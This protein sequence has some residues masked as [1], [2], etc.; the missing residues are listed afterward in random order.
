MLAI[1]LV[2]ANRVVSLD[3]L[4]EELWGDEP[5]SRAI[6]SLQAYVSHLRRL[7][8]PGRS[9]RTP[10]G[11]LQTRPPGYR[12][13]VAPD[14]LDASRFEALVAQGRGLLEAGEHEAAAAVLADGLRLWRGTVLA[15]F[16]DETFPQAERARLEELRLVAQEDRATAE[17][18]LGR[19]ATVAAELERLVA[20]HR[21]REGLHG[22]RMLALY[23]SRPAGRGTAGL[24]RRPA[25]RCATSSASTPSP[26]LRQLQRQILQQSPELDWAPARAPVDA[27]G[28]RAAVTPPA[29]R[30][31]RLVGRG[32]QLAALQAALD[33]AA[34]GHGRAVLLTGEPGIGKTRLAEEATRR[35]LRGG[36]TV[37]WGRCSQEQGAP[38]FWPWVQILRALLAGAPRGRLQ[39]LLGADA[40]ELAQLVP[41]LTDAAGA[42]ARRCRSWTSRPSGSGSRHAVTSLLRRLADDRPLLLVLDDL[43]RADAASLRLLSV[44]AGTLRATRL[45]IVATYHEADADGDDRLAATLAALAREAAVD[46]MVLEGLNRADVAQMIALRWPPIPTRSWRV[47]CT[48]APTATRSTSSSCCVCSAA[49]VGGGRRRRGRR[50]RWRSRPGCATSCGGAWPG[51]RSR[52][53]RCCWSP[54]SSGGSSTSTRSS[55][56]TGLDDE[57]ALEAVEAALLSGLVVE[58]AETVGRFRFVHAL[59]RDVIYDGLSRVRRARLHARVGE[60]LDRHPG[61]DPADGALARAHHWWSATAVVGADV[62]LP[63][64]LAAA[65]QATGRLAHEDA[66]QQ[67]RRALM[68]LAAEPPSPERTRSE[69][70]VQLRLAALSAQLTGAA[71]ASTFATVTRAAELADELADPSATIDRVPEPLRG[72]GGACRARRRTHAGRADA[73]RSPSDPGDSGCSPSRTS[74][75]A[76]PCGARDIRLRRAST[77]NGA[78]SSPV[79]V[80]TPRTSRSRCRSPSGSSSHR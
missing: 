46:R 18:A 37:A 41:E 15:D 79:P 11:V 55:T 40:P 27:R 14:D 10:A 19:H 38:P 6:G 9:A 31:S 71:S 48:S 13:V 45:L 61:V 8:E 58:D 59:V 75:S 26:D 74:P 60:A 73:R 54:P 12:L 63:H 70:G 16:P 44:L 77:W 68:L 62:V 53:T 28:P 22:L 65:D 34:A 72:G 67:L 5:P 66:E 43:H 36:V 20:V 69:L 1:L 39:A 49:A 4:V 33:R 23:R 47:W 21:F 64:L 7:L 78:C 32:Q 80:V 30:G 25:G 3:Q 52:P 42:A 76:G 57:R 17:L 2:H 35:A 56:V 24:T 50:P 51:C 29:V